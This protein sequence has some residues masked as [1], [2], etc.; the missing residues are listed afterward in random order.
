VSVFGAVLW[1]YAVHDLC[2]VLGSSW[3]SITLMALSQFVSRYQSC[4]S[5]PEQILSESGGLISYQL[6]ATFQVY[7]GCALY[8]SCCCVC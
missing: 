6:N 3:G 5:A 4:N 7:W 8:W 1:M 2:S